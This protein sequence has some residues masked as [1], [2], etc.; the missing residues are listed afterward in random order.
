MTL[1]AAVDIG[2]TFTDV[3]TLDDATGRLE[4]GKTLSTPADLTD[5][6]VTGLTGT[7]AAT[8]L[9]ASLVHGS[10][11][12]INA[13]TE[14]RGASVALITTEGFGDVYE[15]GRVNRP[16]AFT[17]DFTRHRPLTG[18]EHVFEVPER[19]RADGRVHRPLDEDAARLV[20]ARV[21]RAGV[22][23]VAVCLLHAYRNPAH[24]RLLGDILAKECPDVFVSLSH[25]LSREYREFERTSTT[26]ANA[27]VGPLVSDYLTRLRL[28]LADELAPDARLFIMQSSGGLSDVDTIRAAPVHM[29]ESGPA[30][31]VVGTIETCR[32]LGLRDA[33]AFDMGG[34]TAKAS[35]IRDLTFPQATEYQ[36]GGHGSGLPVQIPCL[37][38]VEVG[39]GGGSIAWRD[40]A[41]GLHVG[42]RSAGAQ[43]GPA[44][45]GQGGE[46]ATVTDAAVVLGLL[47][48]GSLLSGGLSLDG[49]AAEAAV[50]RVAAGTGLTTAETAGGILAIAA[51]SMAN[52]VRAVTTE[53][54]LDPRDFPLF[55]YGGNGPLHISLVA[56]E[57]GITRVVIPTAPAVFSAVGM[58][59][60]DIRHDSART[61]PARLDDLDPATLD[62]AFAELAAECAGGAVP[63]SAR[64]VRQ[65]DL[66][67]VGQEHTITLD[68]PPLDTGLDPLKR[69]FDA[70]HRERFA[71]DAPDE[72]AELVNLRV[73]VIQPVPR[74]A[75]VRLADG[76]PL[77]PR[78]ALTG[79]R[80]VILDVTAPPVTCP[81]YSR[82]ALLAG[83]KIHGPAAIAEGTTT[84]LL[85]EGDHCRVDD[86]GN[87]HLT[88]G[89]T[90]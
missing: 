74:P 51:A 4:I 76:D 11:V 41:G 44:C 29:M 82:S 75:P 72:P 69:A 77:P 56:R 32:T 22:T 54:G 35:V 78:A 7:G 17:M 30:G 79:T 60:A 88:I 12:V 21:R 68:V 10:T 66:R 16:D 55:A 70:A 6:I 90:R 14:R 53:R 47:P 63:A 19:M 57:L 89:G 85:R 39:T 87:L 58:L 2:G 52:A 15:I 28:R 9:T 37:D 40:E 71:H 20:A 38:I 86:H 43:P 42:P 50:G 3:V 84:T 65:A 34:T 1:R 8:G 13:L 73:S 59:M 83:N 67:Y 5:G 25:R 80:S 33:I 26:V 61:S 31:G 49:A 36:V 45:Y 48:S 62:R 64:V 24:E 23:A 46:Q 18:R 81:V 27:F